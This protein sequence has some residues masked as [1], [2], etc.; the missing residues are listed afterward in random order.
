MDSQHD[1]RLPFQTHT[2]PTAYLLAAPPTERVA[3]FGERFLAAIKSSPFAG[4]PAEN[5]VGSPAS[6]G[7]TR[8]SSG[9][10]RSSSHISKPTSGTMKVSELK[11]QMRIPG[12]THTSF[13][14]TH[15]A[16]THIHSLS[17]THTQALQ[18][19]A[20][21]PIK[22]HLNPWAAFAAVGVLQGGVYG[23]ANIH[24]ANTFKFST[25]K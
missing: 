4:S 10:K 6:S 13:V 21:T 12:S 1:V 7:F 18:M 2:K 8:G 16:H 5:T 9:L 14:H 17:H 20:A 11:R 15:N 23:H 19:T 22:E 25:P 24:L 3:E